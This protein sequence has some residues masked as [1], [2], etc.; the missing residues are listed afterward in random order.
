MVIQIRFLGI[1]EVSNEVEVVP[2]DFDYASKARD[3]ECDLDGAL[4]KHV[5]FGACR[6]DIMGRSH[7][8][9]S[10][11]PNEDF[12]QYANETYCKVQNIR[13][14]EQLK[15]SNELLP[16]ILELYWQNGIGTKGAEFLKATEFVISYE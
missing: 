6:L 1:N 9:N 11:C 7:N 5:D 4:S 10:L 15:E 3:L 14:L 2:M 12:D 8:P 16:S 13:R